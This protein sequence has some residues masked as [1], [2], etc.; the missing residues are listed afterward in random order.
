MSRCF[1]WDNSVDG[2]SE[3][4]LPFTPDLAGSPRRRTF[5]TLTLHYRDAPSRRSVL[6]EVLEED[7]ILVVKTLAKDTNWSPRT[8]THID[9]ID[10]FQWR[11][12]QDG[13]FW[14]TRIVFGL[15]HV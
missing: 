9:F 14:K 4:L 1:W 2:E 5:T 13:E 10:R 15:A 3:L 6:N 12:T 11:R 7:A 8:T